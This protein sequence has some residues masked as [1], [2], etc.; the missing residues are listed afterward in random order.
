MGDDGIPMLCMGAFALSVGQ[1]GNFEGLVAS[2]VTSGS[3]RGPSAS[4]I[5]AGPMSAKKILDRAVV[6]HRCSDGGSAGVGL[7]LLAVGAIEVGIALAQSF[8]LGPKKPKGLTTDSQSDRLTATLVPTEPRKIVFGH[9]AMGTDVRYQAFTA[10]IKN[11][12][13]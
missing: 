13:I 10:R 6:R 5:R 9:T 12:S 4:I 11:I 3:R 2:L 7:P 8:L 1:E